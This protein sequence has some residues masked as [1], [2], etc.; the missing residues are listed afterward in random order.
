MEHIELANRVMEMMLSGEEEIL[1]VLREQYKNASVASEEH[2]DAGFFIN[3][4]VNKEIKVM[5]KYRDTFQIGNVDGTVCGIQGAVGFILFI[6]NGYLTMLEGYTNGI[7]RW[8]EEDSIIK[9]EYDMEQRNV[10]LQR[11]GKELNREKER[12]AKQ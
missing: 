7:D 2:D 10:E 1:S 12:E 3:Y 11:F 8:P 5:D 4:R 6:K 9:L